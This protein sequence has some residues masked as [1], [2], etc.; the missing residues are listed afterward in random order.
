[1]AM[2]GDCCCDT[3]PHAI[4]VDGRAF[5]RPQRRWQRRRAGRPQAI[6]AALRSALASC[7]ASGVITPPMLRATATS[8]G[9]PSS[10]SKRRRRRRRRSDTATP[11]AL[12]APARRLLPA[13][14]FGGDRHARP[15][16]RTFLRGNP[17]AHAGA[18]GGGSDASSS[19]TGWSTPASST[20]APRPSSTPRR[21]A[22][23]VQGVPA[24]QPDVK[25]EKKGPRVGA[26][27]GAIAGISQGR[28]AR[29]D[30]AGQGAARQ[31]GRLLRRRDREA[32]PRRRSR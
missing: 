4:G 27:E 3:S 1:M 16:A 14:T 18:R 26:P 10:A 6:D 32:G 25:E 11:R 9:T 20:R 13:V 7:G 24:R 5:D 17:R 8:S 28:R 31:E 19:P 22:L 30:R 12:T 23:A 29:V 21:L 15:S 2:R